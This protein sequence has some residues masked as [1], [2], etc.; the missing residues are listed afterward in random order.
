MILSDAMKLAGIGLV[1]AIPVSLAVNFLMA[2]LIFGI[3]SIDVAMIAAFTTIL[4][5]VVSAACYLPV[6][7]AVRLDPIIA[8]KCE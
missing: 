3:F 7:R 8:L 5:L 2:S 4:L 1:I 6:R